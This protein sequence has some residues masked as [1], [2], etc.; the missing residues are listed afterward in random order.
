MQD[1]QDMTAERLWALEP[2]FK[3]YAAK[4]AETRIGIFLSRPTLF[5]GRRAREPEGAKKG[6]AS[7]S[8]FCQY[9]TISSD[10]C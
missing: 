8:V 7:T 10:D 5:F 6:R 3:C 9:L 4:G 2:G 1:C